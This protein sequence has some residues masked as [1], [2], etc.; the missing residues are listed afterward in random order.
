MNKFIVSVGTNIET[1]KNLKILRQILNSKFVVLNESTFVPTK[2]EGKTDQADFI[3]GA[4][5]IESSL[6]RNEFYL[7]LKQIEK[8]MG[9]IRTEDK[10]GPRCIDL[11]IT[12]DNGKICDTDYSRYWFVKQT[13]DELLAAE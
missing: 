5:E 1:E 9:R 7:E 12:V 3:N 2:P 11:D 8:Q 13:V 6:N 10:N 4:I